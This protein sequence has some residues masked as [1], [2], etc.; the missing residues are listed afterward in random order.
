MTMTQETRIGLVLQLL[1]N[2]VKS[3]GDVGKN[4]NSISIGNIGK[5]RSGSVVVINCR[6]TRL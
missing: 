3:F 6:L 1:E 5:I 2:A 4:G